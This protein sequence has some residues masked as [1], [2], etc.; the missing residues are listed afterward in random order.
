M[1][2]RLLISVHV[3]D[4]LRMALGPIG[5]RM[6]GTR[7][8]IN[9]WR[10]IRLAGLATLVGP[11]VAGGIVVDGGAPAGQRPAVI[12][13]QNGLPQVNIAAPDNGRVSHN[14]YTQF[15]VDRQGVILNNSAVMTSTG[16]AGMIQG[17]PNLAPNGVTARVILNEVHSST[18]SLLRG[19]MEVAGDRAQIIVANPAGIVCDGCGTINAGRMTLS[20]GAPQRN[21]DGS[22]AGFLVERGVVRIDGGGVNGDLR[23]DARYVDILARAVEINAGVWAQEAVSVVAG[24]N[25]ISA[26]G[27]TV[28]PL[29]ADAIKPELA[30]DMGQ[31]GGMYS[32]HIHMMGTEAGVGVRNQGGHLL[33][34]RTLTV[35]S[36]G[37]LSWLPGSTQAVNQ[38]EPQ[39]VN[40]AVTQAVTQAGGDISLIARDG[41]EHRGKL[42]SGGTLSVESR[43]GRIEQSGTLAAAGDIRL[44]AQQGI[45][46]GGN[47]L[48]GSDINSSLVGSADLL[49]S[50]QGDIRASGSLLSN[51]A[52][53]M[54]GRRVDLSQGAL[55]ADQ[56]QINA[57]DSG[58]ALQRT[59]VDSR[60]LTLD[61]TGSIDAQ[62]AKIRAGSWKVD[63]H[64][65]FNRDAVWTQ[66]ADGDSRFTLTGALDN[67]GGAIE[68]RQL[69][70]DAGSLDN[71]QGRLVA[72]AGAAQRWH[73]DGLLDNRGGELGSNGSLALITGRLDNRSGSVSGLDALALTSGGDIDNKD[74][75]L[76]AGN[77][78]AL[79]AQG[80]LDNARGKVTG[81]QLDVAVQHLQNRQGQ[82]VSWGDLNLTARQALDNAQGWLEAGKTLSIQAGGNWDN[83]NATAVGGQQVQAAVAGLD[84][85]AGKLQ[86][87]GALRLDTS[88]DVGNQAGI[89]T[90]VDTLA[91]QGDAASRFDNTAGSVQSGG[92]MSLKG[93]ALDNLRQGSILSLGRLDLRFAS[94]LDNGGGRLFSRGA[95]QLRA[96]GIR[97]VQGW[98]GSQGD[99]SAAA[100][101]NIDNGQGT[102]Q[103]QGVSALAATTLNNANGVL[104][105][106]SDLTLRLAQD[107]DNR[108][109]DISA[110]GR[111]DLRGAAADTSAGSVDN[112]AGRISAGTGLWLAAQGVSN[113]EG[114]L[115]HSQQ[116]LRLDLGGALDNRQGQVQS[117]DALRLDALRLLN[118]GGAIDS[119][120]Q[121]DLRIVDLLGND[122]GA[123]RSNG[124]QRITAGQVGNRH[125]LISSKRA[126]TLA[127][128]NLNNT[129][130]MLVSQAAGD[131]RVSTLN[132]RQ[133]RI[134]SADALTLNSARLDN[135]AGQLVSGGTFMLNAAG[136][137]N[138]GRGIISSQGQLGIKADRLDNRDGGLLLGT[139][140]TAL[141]AGSLDNASGRVQS[142]SALAIDVQALDNRGGALLGLDALSLSIG[143]DYTHRDGDILSS[144]G[145][146]TLAVNGTLTNEAQWL[147]PGDLAMGSTHF[148]NLGSL[149]GKGVSLATGTLVNRGRL[150][151]DRLT[152]DVDTLDNP[153]TVMG[154]DV[155]VHA[156]VIDNHGRD[157]VVA[158]TRNLSLQARERLVNREGGLLYSGGALTLYSGDLMENRAS[159]IEADGEVAID[160]G[161][162]DNLRE[163]L[164][165]ARD[166]QAGDTIRWQRYNYYWRSYGS[167]VDPDLGPVAPT[168][169]HLTFH[170]EAAVSRD[171]YGTLLAIDAPAKRAQVRVRNSRG[172]L[173]DLWV[174]Y[175]ALTPDD[176]GRYAMTF[177]ETRGYRQYRVPTPYHN[178][179]WREYDQG[180]IEQW[181]PARHVDIADAP[182]VTDYSN[183]R[184]RTVTST[185]TRD[186]LVSEGTGARILAGGN[187]AL[188]ISG[189]LLNDASVITAN[190]N[191]DI[192]G[193]GTVDN[194]GYSIN[195]RRREIIVDHYD[196]D[197]V[198][199][200][201]TFNR[202]VTTALSTVDAVITGNGNVAIQGASI[203][204]TTVDQAQISDVAA[205]QAAVEAERADWLRNP[206]AV[207]VP[208]AE[209]LEGDA[210]WGAGRPLLPAE[211]A[212]TEKQHLNRV[213]TAI[214]NNGLFRQPA[215]PGSPY[216]VVSDTRFT[217]RDKFISSDYLLTQ[218]GFDPARAHKRLG[219]GFYEQRVVREQVLQLT[220]RPSEHGESAMAQ[221]QALMANGARVAQDLRLVPGV[222]L[223]PAQIAALQQD[224][225]WMVSETVDTASGPQTVW[226]PKVYLAASTLRLT[227]DGALI[228]GGALQLSAS[229]LDN[230]GNLFADQALGI[231]ADQFMHRGGDI[232]ADRIEARADSLT[233][234]SNLQDALR[235]AGMSANDIALSGGD[236][237]LRGARL[238]A[239]RNL[240]LSARDNLD[241]GAAKSRHTGSVEVIS[242]AMGNRTSSGME[243]AGQRMAQ[244]S[245]EWQQALGSTLTAGND[246]S[247]TAGRD[248]I[249]QGSQV[250]AGGS[251][252]LQAAGDV[253]LLS[254]STTNRTRLQADSRT[255]S[256]ENHREE[257]RLGLSTLSGDRGVTIQAGN[258]VT[259]E[260]AQLDSQQGRIGLEANDISIGSARR[261]VNDQD[262]ESTREG[263]TR[264][265]RAM[266]TSRHEAVGSTLAGQDGVT[267]VARAGDIAVAGSTLHSEQ[268]DLA[269]WAQKDV[270]I[271]SVTQSDT[272]HTQEHSETKGFLRKRSSDTV[273]DDHVTRETG[274]MLSGDTVRVTAG[275]D[276]TVSG[277]AIVADRDVGLHAGH[278]VDISAATETESHYLLERKK[279]SGLLDSGGIGVTFGSQSSRH[280]VDDKG[281]TQSQSVSTVGSNQGDVTITAGNRV[282]I[283]G[284]DVVAGQ[285]IDITGD[286]VRIAPGYDTRTRTET[287]ESR[288][289]GL[290]IALSGTVGSSLN[291]AVTTARQAGK[292]SDGRLRALQGAKALLSGAQ[293]AQ[294][295]ER[296][297]LQTQA[298]DARNVASGVKAGDK[299]AARGATNT[300][301]VSISVGSQ[302][303]KS[304]THSESL[305]AHGSTLNAGR[306]VSITAT[307]AG[308][309]AGSGNIAVIG[310]QVKAGGDLLLSA[311]ADLELRSAQNTERSDGKSSSHGGNLGVGIG[312]GTGGYGINVSADINAGKG[313]EKGR[314]LTHTETTLDAGGSVILGSGRDTLLKGAQVGGEH[315]GV[316]VGRDL[317]LQSEQDSDHYSSRQRDI[318]AGG[319]FTFGSMTGSANVSASQDKLRSD[320]DS[321]KEQTGLFAGRGG[322]DITVGGHT[323]L[324]GAV[325]ASTAGQDKNQ[326]DTGTLGWRDID[327]RADFEARHSGG[328]MG[329]G[330]PVGKA[331][332]TNAASGV[333]SNA[334]HGG[335][336]SG[337]TKAA[338]SE[339]DLTVRDQPNQR[340]D[341]AGLSR[342]TAHANDGS[343]SPIFNKEKEQNRLRQVQLIG[344]IGGQAMDIIRTQGDI[345]GLKAQTDPKALAEAK[346]QLGKEGRLYT[347]ADVRDRAYG[348]A[349]ARYG[350][351]SDLQKAAQ[352]VTGA[353][354]ALVG[355]NMA[356]ALGS[357]A[358]PYLA[359]EIKRRIGEDNPAANAM[360]HAVLGAVTAQLNDQS[361]LAGGLG[362]GGGE[363]AARVITGQLF[364]GKTPDALSESEKQQVSALSEL[365]AGIAGGLAT[366]DAAGGVTGA[367]AGRNAVENNNLSA[368]QLHEFAERAR[369]CEARG[370]C[371]QV[372]ED[373]ERL[374]VAQQDRLISVCATDPNACRKEYGDIPANSMLV[375]E[376]IDRVLGDSDIPWQ[377]KADMGPLLSQ[378]IDAE[379]VVSS[380]EFAERLARTYGI[381]KDR[382]ELLSGGVLG[383]I[384]G[385]VG[386][387][388][389][390][391][392]KSHSAHGKAGDGHKENGRY[393][394][395]KG[396]AGNM[397]EFLERPGFGSEIKNGSRK[398]SQQYHGQTV[399]QADRRIGNNIKKGD[400]FYLDGKHMDHI[401]VFDGRGNVRCVLNLDGSIN[402][403]KTKAAEGRS[404]K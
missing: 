394:P 256:V 64:D 37:W 209:P 173:M 155:V 327:N 268:G 85:R 371:H 51:K 278:D 384:T 224:I 80:T 333:L 301:G 178:T 180:R 135:Q 139:T 399:Y 163:G 162:L 43:A 83:R 365:A 166:A 403:R 9:I 165:I 253:R 151:A 121:L 311:G 382:A 78:L 86:S 393:Q 283:G 269:L 273:K 366:G 390:S 320:F 304:E 171:R 48:A 227:G 265:Q 19:F 22:L 358:A 392:A 200:Y 340:Q 288:Q 75:S 326:L 7:L 221:Y 202:D 367:Q 205:A 147:L 389:K 131:Y 264:S 222:A 53:A 214:P 225:V 126:L 153:A 114:G 111:L 12:T 184:E 141:T 257:E 97:N 335:H 185:S 242:G 168:T 3:F 140:H 215:E 342:D 117:G 259:L 67:T 66:V 313:S 201:P 112:A 404:L 68:A 319:S 176:D 109:G 52:I 258:S 285:D 244:V 107:I 188:R 36:E 223:S 31:L 100:T 56:V 230:A 385:G 373:M 84:N 261:Q 362:A 377:M 101:G 293:A 197:T 316:D 391:P 401:E 280:E 70:I 272:Q 130:G 49:L 25:R 149:G 386:K 44:T 164:D 254:T 13:T 360:A 93:G 252:Q 158:A 116:Q 289:R 294:A 290:T 348:N 186:Q 262:A 6:S 241:I 39:A 160:A 352:A 361:P 279:K 194:R 167:A 287:F 1:K 296:D 381:D 281:V 400:K 364:P 72:L 357:G 344:E 325:I 323:Q 79:K 378:Q 255:S 30:I 10:A 46:I 45:Q 321:V 108:A 98:M 54:T 191:L 89:L 217:S 76:R 27:K 250:Q 243:D 190:G 208:D 154:D 175:L 125:G 55:A 237:R 62:Q 309:E 74:G 60:L 20:T 286:R 350:T 145:L 345:A 110:A 16:L 94:L 198:H 240:S 355:N 351:G 372:I 115:I 356:G 82:L 249:L 8:W 24:R 322:Y 336:A 236:I 233:M 291:T 331:L 34:D 61:T 143:Q 218:V 276:L 119:Q 310:S 211:V 239:T 402:D 210:Q 292:E 263:K 127:A 370:D 312:V 81:G 17:N 270:R 328:S 251:A 58:I 161:R 274:S 315:I 318:S 106:A 308:K 23:H 95:Q 314:G 303:S 295:L 341:V 182:F 234:R 298:A 57:Q 138:S 132:N 324:D 376:A 380:T 73:V 203:T 246:A 300:I 35:S 347:D 91:W 207:T 397:A 123:L 248:L 379:G 368:S 220:G 226:A 14:R 181:D 374:S 375:R 306:D 359:T 260:G 63:G 206:L 152:L 159:I 105:S 395:N 156:R 29:I 65:L 42:Y 32:G 192:A 369:G 219:D 4:A 69:D 307:G 88:G 247:L 229:R 179:V 96:Q 150:E 47:L 87:G 169:R 299:D 40:Q 277:S 142:G 196:K 330:G 388:A 59:R 50:S 77:R 346:A 5:R 199:W 204:N 193:S 21:A 41:L 99:W 398:T 33:A 329:T 212:L 334:N 11:V 38:A 238:D 172:R 213:A 284:A 228:G 338:V 146:L 343:I 302:S 2:H 267:I 118:E 170:D 183:F 129:D 122:R 231:D 195:E 396:A 104:Q 157:G 189:R 128:D 134:H 187:M 282:H 28:V 245:G 349:M 18:P 26:D 177:Y 102:I 174:N 90:A 353:L 120:R 232:K 113:T 339:G 337:T 383:A 103:S 136:L 332:L 216:L 271:V 387:G 297:D 15:D 92:A 363:L 235:Q 148:T 133:G 137:D 71:R 144:N 266:E 354:T 305:Q 275:N 317:T 124:D